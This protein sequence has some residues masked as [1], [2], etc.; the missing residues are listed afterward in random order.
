MLAKLDH[1]RITVKL[2]IDIP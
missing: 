2:N 1:T